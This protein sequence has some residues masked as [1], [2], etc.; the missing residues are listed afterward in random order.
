MSCLVS[1]QP[2]VNA[3]E[4]LNY[5]TGEVLDESSME[6]LAKIG[7]FGTASGELSVKAITIS[8]CGVVDTD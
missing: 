2:S 6:V 3:T 1:F 7:E 8:N 4:L 5:S